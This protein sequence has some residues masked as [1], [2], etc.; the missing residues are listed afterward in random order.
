MKF[1]VF[2]VKVVIHIV[3]GETR[4]HCTY[5]FVRILCVS[6]L[7]NTL[8]LFTSFKA[9]QEFTLLTILGEFRAL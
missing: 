6:G 1:M 5:N 8:D 2:R 3:L 9:K 4:F 7:K